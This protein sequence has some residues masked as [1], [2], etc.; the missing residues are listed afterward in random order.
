MATPELVV[1]KTV[2]LLKSQI[3]TFYTLSIAFYLPALVL[4]MPMRLLSESQ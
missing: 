3:P 1:T 2:T 4:L